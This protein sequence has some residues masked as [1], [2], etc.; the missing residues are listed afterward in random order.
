M[1]NPTRLVFRLLLLLAFTTVL[2][3]DYSLDQA[4]RAQ[5]L[6]G[7]GIWSQ[8]VRVENDARSSPYPRRLHALVFELAGILWFYTETN[9]TQSFS[10][11][12]GRLDEEKGDFGPLLRDIEPGFVRWSIVPREGGPAVPPARELK[13]GCFIESIA[14]LRERL[15]RGERMERPRLLSY[16]AKSPAGMKGHTVLAFGTGEH[17]EVVDPG[18]PDLRLRFAKAFEP[19]ALA[20]ARAM[21]GANV[22]KARFVPVDLAVPERRVLARGRALS[23]VPERS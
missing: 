18:K 3:A 11:R 17:V 14:A 5:S 22:V 2:R 23:T 16:Y 13:N 1:S 19:D 9:G 7:P 12:V 8:L 21:E 10:L 20:L 4:R 6:L 15:A